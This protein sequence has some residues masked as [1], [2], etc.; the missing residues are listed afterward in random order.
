MG[1]MRRGLGGGLEEI[2]GGRAREVG[3]DGWRWWLAVR[4]RVEE[5]EGGR[6]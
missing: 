3:G 5:E 1:E 2:G 6:G 4:G